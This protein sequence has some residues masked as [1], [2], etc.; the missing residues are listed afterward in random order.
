MS[1]FYFLFRRIIDFMFALFMLVILLVPFIII[2]ICIKVDSKGPVFFLQERIG[3]NGKVFKMIKFRSMIVGAQK[4]GTGVYSFEHDIR[5]TKVGKFIRKTSIDELP[6]II[7]VLIGNMAFVGPRAPVYG[8]FPEYNLLPSYAK[9]RFSVLPGITGLSQ[10]ERRNEVTWEEKIKLD[11]KYIDSVTKYGLFYD[12]KIWFLTIKRVL[13]KSGVE[14]NENNQKINDDF[15][16]K[17]I[18]DG[19]KEKEGNYEN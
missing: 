4:T 16:R 10:C 5:I 18:S 7:N 2:G 8:H 13:S 3:K 19:E 1:K 11:N 14:E 15:F 9:K 6:Q 17:L 12:I